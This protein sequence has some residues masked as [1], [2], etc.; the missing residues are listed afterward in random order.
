MSSKCPGCLRHGTGSM[1]AAAPR[2]NPIQHWIL[3]NVLA[4]MPCVQQQQQQ[5]RTSVAVAASLSS[6][7]LMF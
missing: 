7:V 2:A 1:R 6:A 5:Q 3:G 4:T